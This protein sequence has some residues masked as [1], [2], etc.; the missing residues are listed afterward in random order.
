MVSPHQYIIP[1]ELCNSVCNSDH[2]AVW[3]KAA[4]VIQNDFYVDDCFTGAESANEAITLG[5]DL[6]TVLKKGGFELAE[7]SSNDS[8]VLQ[9]LQ[10]AQDILDLDQD[11]DTKV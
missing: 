3:P 10:G 5:Q 7:W 6:D 2:A 11:A 4:E 1:L 9:A 8:N